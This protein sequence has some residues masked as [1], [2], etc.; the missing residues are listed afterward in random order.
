MAAIDD[1][2]LVELIDGLQASLSYPVS[3]DAGRHVLTV[4]Q[5]LRVISKGSSKPDLELIRAS[6]EASRKTQ[7]RP[8]EGARSTVNGRP[9]VARGGQ[10]RFAD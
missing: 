6:I 3:D 8:A 2:I 5:A 10:W 1:D 9:M 7:G 4:L